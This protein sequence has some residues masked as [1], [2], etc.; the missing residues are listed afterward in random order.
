[1]IVDVQ[2]GER[3]AQE[4]SPG[5]DGDG[6]HRNLHFLED[7]GGAAREKNVKRADDLAASE[8]GLGPACYDLR[9]VGVVMQHRSKSIK[10]FLAKGPADGLSQAVRH[11]VR[12]S[13]AL[14]LYQLDL[15]LLQRSL[16]EAFNLDI[17]L[18]DQ[19]SEYDSIT[20]L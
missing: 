12:V 17:S 8:S 11:A 18:H 5:L 16:I 19:S 6:V 14:A 9:L 15:L 2:V 4:L 3:L 10:V 1:M 20:N 7:P 13:N